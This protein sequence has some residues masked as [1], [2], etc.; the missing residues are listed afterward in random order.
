MTENEIGFKIRGACFSVY[1]ALGP[2]LLESAYEQALVIELEEQGL[3]VESQVPINVRY[4]SRDIGTAYRLD[5]LVEGKVLIELK[6]VDKLAEVYHKQLL[7][8]LKLSH[9]KLGYLLNF[10]SDNIAENIIRYVNSL[11]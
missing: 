9:L 7:T 5:L 11:R 8:Y 4:K 3:K 2:G 1:N 10:N 6:S